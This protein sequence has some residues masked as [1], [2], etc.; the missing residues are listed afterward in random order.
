MKGFETDCKSN[1]EF[2][3]PSVIKDFIF[4]LHDAMR[5]SRRVDEVQKLYDCKLKEITD[6]YFSLTS[7]PDCEA[8]AGEVNNDETFLVFYR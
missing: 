5:R 6:K 7:W 1:M 8:I 2:N 3:I 4:D